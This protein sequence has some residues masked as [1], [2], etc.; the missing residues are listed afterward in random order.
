M[1]SMQTLPKSLR[2]S[3]DP[4]ILS[5]PYM[6]RL[7]LIVHLVKRKFM[8]QYTGAKLGILWSLVPPLAH[9][10]ILALVFGK[11]IPLGVEAYPA[12]VFTAILPWSWFSTS[13]S[14][15]GLL[16]ISNRD[17]LRHPNFD[18]WILIIVEVMLNLL[19]YLILLPML[20]VFLV[21]FNRDLSW[22]IM[23]FPLIVLIQAIL[24]IGA[25]LLV[26]MLNV[27]YRDVQHIVNLG[28]ML[29]FYLTPVFY[30]TQAAGA[31]Y[32][33]LFTLNP[34]AAL[35]QGYRA[36]F[37]YG[38]PPDWRSLSLATLFSCVLCVGGYFVYK[39]QLHNM[40][41]HI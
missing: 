29:L 16:F 18:P 30:H 8:L 6:Y 26:A 12:F 36:I 25:S 35:I 27:F 15:S 7:G 2:A 32:Q 28:V 14:S 31:K 10:L 5:S 41:D 37:F 9:F 17:L 24:I 38:T 21:W 13:L 3:I 39:K 4:K 11:V 34:L 33:I 1:D 19:T 22:Y 20:L 23:L 40:A